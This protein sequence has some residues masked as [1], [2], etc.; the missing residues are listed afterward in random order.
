MPDASAKLSATINPKDATDRQI[1]WASSNPAL[2]TVDQQGNIKML[3][4]TGFA[5]VTATS[6]DGGYKASCTVLAMIH[7]KGISLDQ[8]SMTLYKYNSK[9]L[10]AIFSP[11]DATDKSVSWSSSDTSIASVSSSGHVSGN[12][13]GKATITAK[14]RDG[15][16]AA[17]CIVTVQGEVQ[18]RLMSAYEKSYIHEDGTFSLAMDA[19]TSKKTWHSEE[20]ENGFT[21]YFNHSINYSKG[22]PVLQIPSLYG[23]YNRY[24]DY[25][26]CMLVSRE[27]RN[28]RIPG[29]ESSCV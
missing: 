24:G 18:A 25:L 29:N 8:S 10:R 3:G 16:Y 6:H 11:S 12:G 21:L 19:G 23:W 2:V 17:T 13:Y 1:I 4:K 20:I 5:A 27:V 26:P 7:V 22:D 15:G 28:L 9:S 14:S